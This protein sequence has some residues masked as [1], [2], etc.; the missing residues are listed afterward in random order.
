MTKQLLLS[1]L[2]SL[3]GLF[4]DIVKTE[5]AYYIVSIRR[6]ET[7]K[8]YDNETGRVQAAIDELVNERMNDIYN[9]IRNNQDTYI[10]E[11]GII[12]EKLDEFETIPVLVKKRDDIIEESNDETKIE[13]DNEEPEKLVFN[14]VNKNRPSRRAVTEY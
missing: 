7:D 3:I 6:N 10:L 2:F 8:S 14:F 9:I 11:D 12:D 13:S 4:I 1:V 5:N